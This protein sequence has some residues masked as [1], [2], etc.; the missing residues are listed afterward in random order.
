M[1]SK[2]RTTSQ[3]T[4]PISAPADVLVIS[5][6]NSPSNPLKKKLT[7]CSY[8]IRNIKDSNLSMR[9]TDSIFSSID[10]IS[11]SRIVVSEQ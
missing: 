8:L 11:R 5:L 6:I 7:C 1:S 10:R 9:D 2:I 3:S 4:S